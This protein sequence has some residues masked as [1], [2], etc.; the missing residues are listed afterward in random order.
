MESK[1]VDIH[2]LDI[3]EQLQYADLINN[4]LKEAFEEEKL[5]NT[6]IY[7]NIILTNAQN[8]KETNKKYRNI[9]RETDVLSFP[10]FEKEEIEY[11]KNSINSIPEVLGD[12]MIS[13][14]RVKE[15]AKE[16]GHSF[17]RE[18]SYML[19]HGFYHLMGY[20]HMNEEEKKEMRAKEETI[21]NLLNIKR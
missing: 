9:D 17:E 20:D 5:N 14:E 1:I 15:Q 3:P 10:M 21:L 18:L 11:L 13:I 19:V 7:I 12:I 4:V 2:F 6:N 8:I 16:Y